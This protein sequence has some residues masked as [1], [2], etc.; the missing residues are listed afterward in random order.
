MIQRVIFPKND[1]GVAVLICH[2]ENGNLLT[3]RP[4]E[5]T[6]RKNVPAGVSFRIVDAAEIPSDRSQRNAW[7]ADFSSPDGYGIGAEAWFA[8]QAE[9]DASA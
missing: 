6:A 8:E 7:V 4:I 3:D 5:E 2:D 1:G 9:K